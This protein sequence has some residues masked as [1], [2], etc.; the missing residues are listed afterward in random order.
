MQ[1]FLS[2]AAHSIDSND[3]PALAQLL[4]FPLERKVDGGGLS[5]PPPQLLR[6]F[7]SIE[8]AA[9]SALYDQGTIRN[10]SAW[11]S[12]LR[13]FFG[14]RLASPFDEVAAAHFGAALHLAAHLRIKDVQQ[15]RLAIA[16]KLQHS[17]L[18][19]LLIAFKS[20][21]SNWLVPPLLVVVADTRILAR[22]AD[23]EAS[24][25]LSQVS[26]RLQ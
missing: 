5:E 22:A 7:S 21:N 19:S 18:Q 23:I 25:I 8:N 15:R 11:E 9:K 20:V 1:Q 17:C 4:A 6:L 26:L 13:S 2:A 12:S 14:S 3:G 10:E 16:Y 24:A